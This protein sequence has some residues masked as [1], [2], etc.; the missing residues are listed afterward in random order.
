[1]VNT[2]LRDVHDEII[3][4]VE[5]VEFV[6]KWIDDLTKTY[7]SR[8]TLDSYRV[9]KDQSEFFKT[10]E[11]IAAL[12]TPLIFISGSLGMN[13]FIPGQSLQSTYIFWAIFICSL[14]W[15]V[16]GTTYYVI[17]RKWNQSKRAS[18]TR[19]V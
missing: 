5:R 13:V 8:I 3:G 19:N 6:N 10:F 9:N 18:I 2:Y 15:F 1:M 7:V 11:V 4:V 17:K 12:Y 16:V 14:L